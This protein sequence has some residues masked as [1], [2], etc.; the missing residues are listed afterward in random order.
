MAMRKQCARKLKQDGTMRLVTEQGY[1]QTEAA[2][3]LGTDR[4]MLGRW[5]KEPQG[6]ES[7]AFGSRRMAS[8]LRDLGY[9][10]GRYQATEG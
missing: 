3:S 8:A 2:R 10:V 9:A 1:K 5:V 6:D 4:G 7:E